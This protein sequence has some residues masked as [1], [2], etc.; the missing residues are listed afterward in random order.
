MHQLLPYIAALSKSNDTLRKIN[1]RIQQWLFQ[2]QQTNLE[3][4]ND[5]NVWAKSIKKHPIDENLP[6]EEQRL[7]KVPCVSTVNVKLLYT[8]AYQHE[9]IYV[10]TQDIL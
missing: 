1:Y 6:L 7:N 2:S 5:Y 9:Q 3:T 8:L 4:L 10:V